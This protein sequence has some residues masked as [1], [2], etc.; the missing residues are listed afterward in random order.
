MTAFPSKP[1]A[2][3]STL[4]AVACDYLVHEPATVGETYVRTGDV[5]SLV[6]GPHVA[7]AAVALSAAAQRRDFGRLILEQT[8]DGPGL[9]RRPGARMG[10]V[11]AAE[12]LPLRPALGG[13]NGPSSRA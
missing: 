10:I 13:P 12:A 9:A 1:H 8:S 11:S 2:T 5:V 4:P 7:V 6:D 3:T